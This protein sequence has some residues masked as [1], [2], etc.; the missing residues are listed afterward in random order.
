M[1]KKPTKSPSLKYYY[2]KTKLH[3]LDKRYLK[4]ETERVIKFFQDLGVFVDVKWARTEEMWEYDESGKFR[5]ICPL[6]GLKFEFNGHSLNSP[7]VIVVKP[8]K[9]LVKGNTLVVSR[10]AKQ[11]WLYGLDQGIHNEQEYH[12]LVV[13]LLEQ[14]IEDEHND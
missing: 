11:R 4:S 14:A 2:N 10:G 13:M 3:P 12:K 5:S 9:G 6:S 8:K 1:T 7:T